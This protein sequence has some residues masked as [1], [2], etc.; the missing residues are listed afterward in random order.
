MTQAG[1][2]DTGGRVLTLKD[3]GGGEKVD[4]LQAWF[5]K[6]L[7]EIENLNKGYGRG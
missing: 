3:G 6:S 5:S 7:N 1:H 2:L 4:T